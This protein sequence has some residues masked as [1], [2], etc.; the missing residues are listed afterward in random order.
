MGDPRK[1]CSEK[2]P[3][4]NLDIGSPKLRGEGP[5][6]AKIM[7]VGEAPGQ[8]EDLEGRP[9]VGSSGQLLDDIFS[10]I[11]LDREDVYITN[12]V[13]C[14]TPV[15]N[16]K[17]G[18][19]DITACRPHLLK[20]I[21]E[22]KP[23][24]VGCL[25][26]VA[27]EA[28]LKRTGITK[29]Q[30]NVF[31]S[32]ELD[33]KVIPVLHP[34]YILRNPSAYSSLQKGMELIK[35]ESKKK[36][37]VDVATT[38]TKHIDADTPKK[39]DK[40]LAQLEK[41]EAF[42]FDLETTSLNP[43]EAKIILIALSWQGGLGITIKWKSLSKKQKHRLQE[44][45]LSK[46]EKAGHN[47]KF[48]IQVLWSNGVR[49]KGP[50]FDTLPAMALINENIK[51]KGLD[52]L[53]LRYLD[54]GEYWKPLDE[55]KEAYLKKH[56][57]K[58]EDFKY[59]MIP[60]KILCGYAQ[61]DADATHRLY[62]KF[63]KELTRQEL[64]KFYKKYTLPT[65]KI[66]MQVEYRGIKV[67]RKKLKKLIKE[68]K[69]KVI[70][71]GKSIQDSKSV[72]KYQKIRYAHASR[73][74]EEKW[75]N[76]KMLRSRFPNAQQYIKTR[77]K[78]EDWK[79]N[80]RSPKQLREMLFDMMKLPV[81]EHTDTGQA[82][83]KE[84][85]LNILADNHNVKIAQK[86]IENR[87]LTKFLSTYLE[88]VY[89]KSAI[90]GRI[91]PNYLQHRAVTGR[92]SSENP[93]FQ[94]IPRD[95]KDFK[96]CFIADPGMLIVKADLAQ[97]EF[98][99]WAHYS[100]DK[101]MISD[102]ESGMDIHRK[103]ASE[104]FGVPEEEVTKDQRTAAKN[105]VAGDTWIPTV[106]GMKKISELQKGNLVLD[107]FNRPQ[108]ITETIHK[109]DDIF[110]VDT[111]CG[112]IKCT[113]DHPFYVINENAELMFKP[114]EEL[115]SGDYIL[116]CTPENCCTKYITWEYPG[117]DA[118][119]FKP[120]FGKWILNPDL[121]Y[122]VGFIIA[123]G[124][125]NEWSGGTNVEWTQKG[126]F[127]EHIDNISMRIFG[128]RLKRTIDPRTGVSRWMVYSIEFV[129]FLAFIGLPKN[130]IKGMKNFP[131]AI[132]RSPQD[133][134]KA[135][136]QGYFDGDGTF[137]N[138]IA[139]V[140]TVSKE[141]CDGICLLLRNF[142]IYSKIHVEYPK[143]GEDFYNIHIT[144]NEE[145]DI[146]T[147]K[148]EVTVPENW[149]PPKQ[150]NGRKFL[151]NVNAFYQTKHPDC[152]VRYHTKLRKH[153]THSFLKKNCLGVNPEI[154]KLI[155]HGIYSVR[156]NSITKL[157]REKVYDFVTTGD[158][159]MVA[160]SLITLDCVFGLMY[161]RGSKAIAAQYG[162]SVEDADEVR[163]LF[164][165][166]Y[167]MA[168]LWLDKQVAHAEEKQYVKTWMGR[169]RRLPEIASDDHMIKA[170][171]E[172]QAKNCID[173]KTEVLTKRG[174]VSGW[175]L[176]L[177][178][179]ILTKNAE[180]GLLEWQ[181]PTKINIYGDYNGP[182]YHIKS[183]SFS[184]ATTPDHRW[185][186]FD[187]ST[188]KNICKTSKTIS[189]F[190]DHR[191]HRTGKYNKDTSEINN[192]K[193]VTLIGWIIADGSFLTSRHTG[194][195]IQ[196]GQSY[197]ANKPKVAKIEQ[198][199]KSLKIKYSRCDH[200]KTCCTH[201]KFFG[202]EASF[203][204]SIIPNKKLTPS[205]LLALSTQQL[206]LLFE[207]L[208]DGDGHIDKYN[209]TS[210]YTADEHEADIFQFL[211]VLLGKASSKRFDD[212]TEYVKINAAKCK[213][214]NNIPS[215]SHRW[216]VTVLNRDKVQVLPKQYKVLKEH[217]G[218]WC[219]TVPNSYIVVRREGFVY[220][221]G[222]SPI[223]GLASDM[224]NHFMVMTLKYAKKKQIKCYPFG[225][226][227]DANL[228]QVKKEEA[229]KLIKIMKKVVSTAFLDFKCKMVLDFEV[230]KTLGT[231]REI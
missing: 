135:F 41:V 222:N 70:Q 21:E 180:S 64:I 164:F 206:Q 104:V 44:I 77:I 26:A 228:I 17:P 213:K 51:D 193:L 224:N 169:I 184:A 140:G 97:A 132:M 183:K 201:F 163:N 204:R 73:T 197:R 144:T 98:R 133:V 35:S 126:K 22:I 79:F 63:K 175:E 36:E 82:S 217:R 176:S 10:E 47:L 89:N 66:I 145:L 187:K 161:G 114:L 84:E 194:N 121:A 146:L 200:K 131:D 65:L 153:I 227:H 15:E 191:I 178:D 40:V 195:A 62:V 166:N 5:K 230:G 67:N 211:C 185:L 113:K 142:G 129:E 189:K 25:G 134:Q 143:G 119:A 101:Q 207:A 52:A 172:R 160:N 83:T 71:S 220:I 168:A 86:I 7:L 54:L 205:L 87:K 48:D 147:K 28:V 6:K 106:S 139:C 157:G 92:L 14:A 34:A 33:V 219:P 103:T 30:N 1:S 94:N 136:L 16:K 221:T 138:H 37:K 81:I 165:K 198:L 149:T 156:I 9:F 218:V 186:V 50:F 118:P 38:K 188:R 23:N 141:L 42:T 69:N 208:I 123:E 170:E 190:G 209:K 18:K 125:L 177:E 182:I 11:R 55:F 115:S 31:Y 231:L 85:V 155:E 137:K 152:D 60:Y 173:F 88:S 19:K 20:E 171:A 223:Q 78:D 72:K 3:R 107:H 127:V 39:I 111:E 43:I 122:L 124:T 120:L 100:N 95:A 80:P 102:I 158:K 99:C 148:I 68:Y 159:V 90:D 203:I 167:P 154:D 32:K 108:L 53:T 179:Y 226:I 174:W 181:K 128:D 212:L 12:A 75:K 45:F 214:M 57:M 8:D 210:F 56:K 105:C 225:T 49:I 24:V 150:N 58:K 96:K 61:G 199:L 112:S 29:L 110:L 74:F 196:I 130:K 202:P 4:L 59:D 27:L 151:H 46:K 13:K 76:S 93:N 215:R 91:H 116:S 216:T 192:D 2:C 162:I 117:C 229:K 109:E